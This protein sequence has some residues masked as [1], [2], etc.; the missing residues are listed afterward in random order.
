MIGKAR[1][2]LYVPAHRPELLAKAMAGPADA[3]VYDL[4]D[5]VVVRDKDAARENAVAAAGESQPKPL[6][7]RINSPESAWGEKDIVALA[8]RGLAGVRVPKCTEP[9][10][11]ARTGRPVGST[12]HRSSRAPRVRASCSPTATA[13]SP[14]VV[15]RYATAMHGAFMRLSS[16]SGRV[17]DRAVCGACHGGWEASGIIRQSGRFVLGFR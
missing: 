15:A 13:S 16:R 8:G 17:T 14:P 2:W 9:G 5:A 7:V 10:V 6:W 12:M 11:V 1:S 3:V 4:E